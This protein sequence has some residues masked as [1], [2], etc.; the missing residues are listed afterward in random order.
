VNR[1]PATLAQIAERTESQEDFGRLLRDWLHELRRVSSRPQVAAA[2]ADIP[3]AL[4]GRFLGGTVADAWLAAYGEHLAVQAGI[5][6]PKWVFDRRRTAPEPWFAD[7]SGNPALR[8][9]VLRRTPLP[10]KRRNLYTRSVELPLDLR[11]GRPAKSADE[12]RLTNAARQHRFR[13]RRRLELISLRQ[14]TR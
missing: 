4:R 1:R 13:Q 7:E 3:P 11:S 6:P 8:A 2:I 14:L 5:V 12:K 9:A 10:F